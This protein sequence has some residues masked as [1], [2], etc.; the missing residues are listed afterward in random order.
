[1]SV[2][3]RYFWWN[4][5]DWVPYSDDI[6]GLIEA[7]RVAG[8]VPQ[9]QIDAA[10]YI[11]ISG[12][13]EFLQ[14]RYD[15]PDRQ[16]N[17]R[18][19]EE[20]VAAPL[21]PAAATIAGDVFD[22]CVVAFL[23]GDGTPERA[24]LERLVDANGGIV[25]KSVAHK[26]V[27]HVVVL[28][29]SPAAA[30]AALKLEPSVALV[31]ADFVRDSVAATLLKDA[32]A[33]AYRVGGDGV[34]AAAASPS[35]SSSLKRKEL[36]PS[37]P[38]AAGAASPKSASS[39]GASSLLPRALVDKVSGMD[40]E[41]H[42]VDDGGDGGA[43]DA[44][45]NQ[46]NIAK[47]NNKFYKMQ[48]LKANGRPE[49]RTWYRWGRVGASGQSSNERFSSLD[50]AK[51][52]F[53]KKFREKTKNDWETRLVSFT[54]YDGKYDLVHIAYTDEDDDGGG[55]G[56][57]ARDK[58][59]RTEA[60]P[61]SPKKTFSSSV[62]SV[63]SSGF[64]SKTPVVPL[65][66][67]R[68]SESSTASTA[69][70]TMVAAASSAAASSSSAA[71]A[72]APGKSV[73]HSHS[74]PEQVARFVS[75]ICDVKAMSDYMLEMDIDTAKMPL[76]KL[77][78]KQI[79][80][81]YEIL[82]RVE[83][84]LKGGN[85]KGVFI[86]CS[87]QFYT[88]IPHAFG[89]KRPPV[90]DNVLALEAKLTMLASL[91]EM[92]VAIKMLSVGD[93]FVHPLTANYRALKCGMEPVAR[94]SALFGLVAR[95]VQRTHAAT[96]DWF[97]LDVLDVLE[98]DRSGE[99]ESFAKYKHLKR[100]LLW[101]GSRTTNFAGIIGQGLRIAPPEAPVTGYMFGKGV[102]FADSSSKSA[103]YCHCTKTQP[104][105]VMA[106]C[107]VALGEMLPLRRAEF[108]TKLPDGVHSTFGVGEWT[109]DPA[110]F[111]KLDDGV[112]V[113][114][115]K[116]IPSGVTKGDGADETDLLYNEFIV[117]DV[118]QIRMRYL[119]KVKFNFK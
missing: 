32:K 8:D 41:Y 111:T 26:R 96:H 13:D 30:A 65:S 56:D 5:S 107:D 81:G 31:N 20:R 39:K 42:V 78:K 61:V 83:A 12:R 17:V 73:L 86:D 53:K 37:R 24:E 18:R 7:A 6:C 22:E 113:P 74:L 3:A 92:E 27:T 28:G 71:A 76:G 89:M 82:K 105:G 84:E 47:N 85:A 93:K 14:Q 25:A 9:V 29:S 72:A 55:D 11:S 114:C 10:R 44:M 75:M 77:S 59:A 66:P 54:K 16:R 69:S 62:T 46:T 35:S 112:E 51:A 19:V 95:Y 97:T 40:H 52:S 21:K 103:N 109:P 79:Q 70:T 108:I 33:A 48:L 106:L 1:M 99:R 43:W 60:T 45:L 91:A 118:A 50:S 116:L 15:D 68:A 49:W 23:N 102:Y 98:A 2:V 94:D 57:A 110:G 115:G 67:V 87:N 117:Y 64:S 38:V 63:P 119:L 101:H 80:K 88:L 100:Q 34:P 104:F 4:D 90:L 58:R 36:E